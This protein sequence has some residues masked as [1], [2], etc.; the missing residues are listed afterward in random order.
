MNYIKKQKDKTKNGLLVLVRHGESRLNE[1]NVFTGWIDAPLNKKGF[2]EA[3]EVSNHC[4]RFNYDAAFTSH[5]ERAHGTLLAIL[6]G[7]K[8]IGLF[9]HGENN[10]YNNMQ[11][12]PKDFIDKSF[13]IFM[14]RNLN[15][16]SYGELQGINKDEAA[17]R[18]GA[19]QVL[20]W[21]RGFGERPPGGESLQDVYG[22]VIPYF[23]EHIHSRVMS[24]E[25]VLIVAHGNTLRAVIKFLERIDDGKIPFIDIPTGRPLVYSCAKNE[26]VR[27]EGEYRFDRPLR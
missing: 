21:R 10:L 8:E 2:E 23:E 5:L 27:I 22:R 9:D 11:K 16:R 1:L 26:F 18:F 19:D 25:V 17:R 12:A 4:S 15:E 13:P 6:A 20:K 24:G 14:N 7:Q 3:F